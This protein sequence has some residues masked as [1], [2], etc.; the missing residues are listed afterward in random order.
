MCSIR[1]LK[2][3]FRVDESRGS[4]ELDIVSDAK[5]SSQPAFKIVFP[6]FNKIIYLN[7]Y[8]CIILILHFYI[9][10]GKK[11]MKGHINLANN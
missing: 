6:N 10:R 1:N 7:K 2:G 5:N 11:T 8:I 4:T 3:F 9:T